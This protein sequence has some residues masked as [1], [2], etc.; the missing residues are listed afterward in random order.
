MLP[1]TRALAG[2]SEGKP[3]CLVLFDGMGLARLGLHRAGWHTIPVELEVAKCKLSA[4]MARAYGL[5]E[6]HVCKDVLELRRYLTPAVM[7]GIDAIWASP[8]CQGFSV[9][10]SKKAKKPSKVSKGAACMHVEDTVCPNI[11]KDLLLWSLGLGT[12][13]DATDFIRDFRGI[14]WV[15]NVNNSTEGKGADGRKYGT[16]GRVMNQVQFQKLPTQNRNR[17]IG[18]RYPLPEVQRKWM[19]WYRDVAG[20]RY[21]ELT[22]PGGQVRLK[23]VVVPPYKSVPL[24]KYGCGKPLLAKHKAPDAPAFVHALKAMPKDVA[25]RLRMCLKPVVGICPTLMAT[26]N[27]AT[28]SIHEVIPHVTERGTGSMVFVRENQARVLGDHDPVE[29]LVIKAAHHTEATTLGKAVKAILKRDYNYRTG[30]NRK[31][32]R[33]YRRRLTVREGAAVMGVPTD[34][35]LDGVLEAPPGGCSEIDWHN[36]IL[37]G[38]GN[39]VP[40]VMAEALGRAAIAY[41]H[42]GVAPQGVLVSRLNPPGAPTMLSYEVRG[43]VSTAEARVAAPAP[44]PG[45]KTIHVVLDTSSV[46]MTL[47]YGGAE[48][49]QQE[50]GYLVGDPMPDAMVFRYAQ[51]A[52]A[53]A[54]TLQVHL[55]EI[56]KMAPVVL[57][58]ITSRGATD[59]HLRD[60]RA[61]LRES[62]EYAGV[63]APTITAGDMEALVNHLV[64]GVTRNGHV[65]REAAPTEADIV[66]FVNAESDD[67][68]YEHENPRWDSGDPDTI[69]AEEAFREGLYDDSYYELDRANRRAAPPPP[70]RK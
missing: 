34:V 46:A 60:V 9:A 63:R 45:F 36:V 2:R 65:V 49:G 10:R 68:K 7:R 20:V 58:T 61:A 51:H 14:L 15:E 28:G 13:G 29:K 44:P 70:R 22:S 54:S 55:M 6:A 53:A 1:E 67:S 30:D 11:S 38:L 37:H 64:A 3:T 16:W 26:D 31:A 33:Y 24:S 47:D 27:T 69:A 42:S 19:E 48:E 56:D 23:R 43:T 35:R 5:P 41:L 50:W 21:E 32:G 4:V 40:V 62:A 18:G 39:G 25:A 12:G 66:K 8:P 59:R 17:V 57:L 52:R